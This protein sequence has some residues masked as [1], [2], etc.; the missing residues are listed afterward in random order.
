MPEIL[1]SID[2]ASL[3]RSDVVNSSIPFSLAKLHYKIAKHSF[4]NRGE[5]Y[6]EEFI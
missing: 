4:Q 3:Y 5:A 2:Q 6:H 1:P